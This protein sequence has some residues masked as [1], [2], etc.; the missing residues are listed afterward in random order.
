MTALSAKVGCSLIQS[1]QGDDSHQG[2]VSSLLGVRA[3]KLNF[4]AKIEKRWYYKCITLTL[5]LSAIVF[6][7]FPLVILLKVLYSVLVPCLLCSIKV[8]RSDIFGISA[9]LFWFLW[10]YLVVGSLHLTSHLWVG[11]LPHPGWLLWVLVGCWSAYIEFLC[12][13]IW[14]FSC[15]WWVFVVFWACAQLPALLINWLPDM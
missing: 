4:E 13:I 5:T 15:A 11:L 10:C 12:Y 14:V 8:E 3:Y 1:P 2:W 6:R 7:V 9:C